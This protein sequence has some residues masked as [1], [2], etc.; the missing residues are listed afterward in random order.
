MKTINAY[1]HTEVT[2]QVVKTLEEKGVKD[3]TVKKIDEIVHWEDRDQ[4]YLDEYLE[5][6]NLI[7]KIEFVCEDRDAKMFCELI[8]INSKLS[9]SD[10]GVIV[11]QPAEKMI[12]TSLK[13][14]DDVVRKF[15]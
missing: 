14:N 1:V 2:N 3:L 5:K 13:T 6:H 11:V 4:F 9:T 8:K 10:D 12:T 7:E 15:K